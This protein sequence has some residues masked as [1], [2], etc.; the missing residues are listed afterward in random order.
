MA[1]RSLA[2]KRDW[3]KHSCKSVF[4]LS[5]AGRIQAVLSSFWRYGEAFFVTCG[6]AQKIVTPDA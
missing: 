5:N 1:S 4:T 2:D 3:L 6:V